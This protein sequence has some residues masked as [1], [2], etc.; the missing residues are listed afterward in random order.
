[1]RLKRL[2]FL[3][4]CSACTL[5][6]CSDVE[7]MFRKQFAQRGGDLSRLTSVQ[8]L[9]KENEHLAERV[10]REEKEK[11][12]ALNKVKGLNEVFTDHDKTFVE[13]AK[14]LRDNF[15]VAR[16]AAGTDKLSLIAQRDD[17]A[18]RN[19]LLR[20]DN[21]ELREKFE[22]RRSQLINANSNVL[23]LTSLI[24]ENNAKIKKLENLTDEKL[25]NDLEETE[26]TAWETEK[27]TLTDQLNKVNDEKNAEI[28][29][30]RSDLKDAKK[31]LETDKTARETENQNLTDQLNKANDEKNAEIE[32]LRS[33]LEEANEKVA[34]QEEQLAS[35][36]AEI[37]E[38][39]KINAENKAHYEEQKQKQEELANNLAKQEQ[40]KNILDQRLAKQERNVIK[41]GEVVSDNEY[42]ENENE[43][44]KNE[45]EASERIENELWS[46][47]DEYKEKNEQQEAEIE[48]LTNDLAE[49]NKKALK[50]FLLGTDQ[51]IGEGHIRWVV[52]VAKNP[53][54]MTRDDVADA[55]LTTIVSDEATDKLAS[56]LKNNKDKEELKSFV[57]DL[58]EQVYN[59]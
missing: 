26:K 50:A 1:M 39:R 54:E 38:L 56:G 5:F 15:R 59:P 27:Q 3:G 55:V 8:K 24:D 34:Q 11:Q 29:K 48:K 25:R 17:Q 52:G 57:N 9:S 7:A 44:L 12:E 40:T 4:A 18:L 2:G 42:L 28:E 47:L 51:N 49:A 21:K 22:F 19:S 46:K 6:F 33:D 10:T 16:E 14:E 43:Q 37:E 41:I 30:L 23:R 45:Q 31:T 58:I 32:K 20:K 53:M 13:Q 35:K 36:N